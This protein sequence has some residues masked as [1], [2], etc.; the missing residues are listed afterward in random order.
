MERIIKKIKKTLYIT[1]KELQ[2]EWYNNTQSELCHSLLEIESNL[3]EILE[4]L[5][6]KGYKRASLK[7][8]K[9]WAY[10]LIQSQTIRQRRTNL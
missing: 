6:A 9:K 8:V 10:Y 1:R 5:G 2:K 4:K 7:G 3:E